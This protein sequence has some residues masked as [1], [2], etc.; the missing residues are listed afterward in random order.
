MGKIPTDDYRY[1]ILN[2][3]PKNENGMV[4]FR[5]FDAFNFMMVLLEIEDNFVRVL[6]KYHK[7]IL[8]EMC[9]S[10]DHCVV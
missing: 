2:D 8:G 3:I 10:F 6:Y 7:N 9:V 4:L 5:K 1:D